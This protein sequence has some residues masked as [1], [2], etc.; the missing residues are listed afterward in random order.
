MR[1]LAIGRTQA[2]VHRQI[3]AGDESR[4]VAGEKGYYISGAG[5]ATAATG[6]VPVG[7][8]AA[9]TLAA[10]TGTGTCAGVAASSSSADSDVAVG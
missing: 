2:T 9:A 5:K 3:H 8:S 1:R 7:D 10:G 4:I 6:L